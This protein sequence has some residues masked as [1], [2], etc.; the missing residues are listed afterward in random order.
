[1]GVLAAANPLYGRYNPYKSPVENIDL[2][3]SLLSRFD[4]L[5]LLLDTVDQEKDKNLALHVCKVHTIFSKSDS[6]KRGDDP[7]PSAGEIYEFKPWDASF[8]RTYIRKARTL[9]PLIDDSIQKDIVNAYV[10]IRDEEKRG[11]VDSRKSYTT[12]RTLL[13]ILRLSQ[14]HARARFSE[15]VERQDFDEAMR[16]M[17]AS[18]ESVELSA[19]KRNQNPLDTVYD[20]IADLSRRSDS[21]QLEGWVDMAH[22]TSM[23][24]HRGLSSDQV[25]EAVENWEGLLVLLRNPGQTH[26]KF[27]VPPA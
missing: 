6:Q 13:A 5:F 1:M 2:P 27:L 26:V 14:A 11:E 8:L 25:V 24:G 17:K 16:L 3:A 7:S 4:L 18:K 21:D 23:C 15:R 22:V 9:E 20:I 10:N 19:K 12:P